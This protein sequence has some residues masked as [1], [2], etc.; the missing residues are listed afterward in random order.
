MMQALLL[1]S[2][3]SLAGASKPATMAIRATQITMVF[4]ISE[5]ERSK[6]LLNR[7]RVASG[8][9]F[10]ARPVSFTQE[11]SAP[12]AAGLVA[13]PFLSGALSEPLS[14]CVKEL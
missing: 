13:R 7:G 1:L 11:E 12:R 4:M 3:M 14:I 2:N 9:E 10:L 6:R 8:F 5:I